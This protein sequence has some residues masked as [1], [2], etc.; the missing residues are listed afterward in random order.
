MTITDELLLGSQQYADSFDG[1]D[2]PPPPAKYPADA[3]C[4]DARLNVDGPLGR[5]D[6]VTGALREVTSSR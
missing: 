4:L 2:L 3:A 5:Y 1:S 6:R